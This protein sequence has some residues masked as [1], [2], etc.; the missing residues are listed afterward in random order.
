MIER[1]EWKSMWRQINRTLDDPSLGAIPFL[2][3]MEGGRV[4]D[5]METEAMNTEIQVVTE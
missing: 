3:C 2:Q 5:I 1:E 4:V